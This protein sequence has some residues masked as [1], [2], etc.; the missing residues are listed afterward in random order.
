MTPPQIHIAPIDSNG[1]HMVNGGPR[2]TPTPMPSRVA[3]VPGL[4]PLQQQVFS[5]ADA[6][7]A[8]TLT[9][10]SKAVT[11]LRMHGVQLPVHVHAARWL[12]GL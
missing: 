11:A 4:T 3:S 12:T 9:A 7:R 10:N 1:Q 5:L 2:S 8:V 6:L